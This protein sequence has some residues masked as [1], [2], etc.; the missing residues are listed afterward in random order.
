ML[1]SKLQTADTI[2]IQFG[3]YVGFTTFRQDSWTNKI[4]IT[5]FCD[6]IC[7]IYNYFVLIST[8]CCSS[9]GSLVAVGWNGCIKLSTQQQFIVKRIQY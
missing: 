9:I 8:K 7:N 2:L 3:L 5:T 4:K 1:H 6:I